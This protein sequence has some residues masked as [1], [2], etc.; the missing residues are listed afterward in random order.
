MR[1]FLRER[2]VIVSLE[3]AE[4]FRSGVEERGEAE[5]GGAVR[6]KASL[7]NLSF[8]LSFS[9]DFVVSSARFCD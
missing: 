5:G 6:G 4:Q 1:G 9:R 3:S 7:E 2:N 8:F